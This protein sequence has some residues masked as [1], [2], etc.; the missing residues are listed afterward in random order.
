MSIS[1][2]KA[3]RARVMQTMAQRGGGVAIHLTAPERVRSRDTEYPY[4]FDSHFWYLTGFGE[5]GAALVLV[6]R[7][8]VQK[9]I[10]LCRPRDPERE[11]WDGY[12]HG[13][14]SAREAFGFDEA[15]SIDDL[16]RLAPDWLAD[17]PAFY[18]DLSAGTDFDTRVQRWLAV[19]RGRVRS[20]VQAPGTV[21][22]LLALV[23]EMRLI[24]HP[25]EIE[26]MR[27]AAQISATA[28]ARAMHACHAGM[29]EYELE[30]ELLHEFR[31]HGAAA[32]AYGSIVAAGANACVLH[33]PAG[34]AELVEGAVCLIDAGCEIE[35]YAADITRTF[36]VNGRFSAEQR[37][38]YEI[39]FDAQR[40]AIDQIF[41]GANFN[42]PHEAAT[43]VL[44]Q[45][46]IDLGLI[47]GTV[48][49]AIE[50]GAYRQ[51]YM[52]R[53][54]HWIG[55]DVHDVGDYRAPG[56]A[57]IGHE[58]P[59]RRLEPGMALTVEPGL[60]LR[61]AQNVPERFHDIGV[62]IEDDVVVTDAGCDVL[63]KAAPKTIVDIEALM[64]R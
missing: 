22:D 32:P 55:L 54:G 40:A 11:T 12:R 13:P 39:V 42:A 15:C 23:D 31:R 34:N 8:G 63:T 50:S 44:T 41:P 9:A 48:D 56:L 25:E 6:V 1:T 16:D 53:T 38:V 19:V 4:R 27:R 7:D 58:R 64:Q 36:P 51:F 20:G 18:C 10:L 17:A 61:A 24:K 2:F 57:P 35:G 37:A 47:G 59:W 26:H 43:R 45:G 62:R 5:P 29:R 60:Y 14:D 46:M 30:A 33:Y 49:G 21:T 3:R 28:H 52:H